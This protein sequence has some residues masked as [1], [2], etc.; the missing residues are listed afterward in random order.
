MLRQASSFASYRLGLNDNHGVY[1]EIVELIGSYV[2]KHMK[3]LDN[4]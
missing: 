4:K 1:V 3:D 2:K